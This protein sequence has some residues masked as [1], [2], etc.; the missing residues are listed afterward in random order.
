MSKEAPSVVRRRPPGPGSPARVSQRERGAGGVEEVGPRAVREVAGLVAWVLAWV[1]ASGVSGASSAV[2]VAQK[3][4]YRH[5]TEE[6]FV[7]NMQTAGRNY[8]G[9]N[10]FL[11]K[12][13]Y[14]SAKAQLTR[15]REQLAITITFWRDAK[16]DD[17]VE[18][19]RATLNAMDDL[20]VALGAEKVDPSVLRTVSA[21]ITTTCDA[22]HAVYREPNPD[23]KGFR[24]KPGSVR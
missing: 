23:K 4:P 11:A 6:K 2:T 8:E 20:D 17:A 21:R 12:N 19:L 10:A 15:A 16:K 13:D 24:V 22:C 3:N 9:V 14:E 18:L 7:E 1:L 5:Y